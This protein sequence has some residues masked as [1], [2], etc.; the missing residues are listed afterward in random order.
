MNE[1]SNISDTKN[2]II[3]LDSVRKIN[4]EQT[5][6]DNAI[7]KSNVNVKNLE[8]LYKQNLILKQQIDR[9]RKILKKAREN[10]KIEIEQKYK[11]FNQYKNDMNSIIEKNKTELISEQDKV[12]IEQENLERDKKTF[13]ELKKRQQSNFKLK[14]EKQASLLTA[15]KNELESIELDLKLKKEQIDSLRHQ[16]EFDIVEFEGKKR[17]LTNNLEKFNKL[18]SSLGKGMDK[19]KTEDKKET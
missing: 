9:D 4:S 1:G 17:D 2:E 8:D 15:K 14:Q 12:T 18:V 7:K 19:M 11:E 5:D 10:F 16:L 3:E 6:F 13:E